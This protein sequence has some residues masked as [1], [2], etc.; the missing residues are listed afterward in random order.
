ML[1]R[2]SRISNDDRPVAIVV[3]TEWEFTPYRGL[4]PGLRTVDGVGPWEVYEARAG[5]QTVVLIVSGAG[6]VNAAAAT[7]RLIAGF[8]PVAVLHGG[9]AGA[10]NPALMPGDI[11]LGDRYIIAAPDT[12]RQARV[13]RGLHPSLIRFRRH[14]MDVHLA[15]IVA[16][17]ELLQRAE[18]LARQHADVLG[19]WEAPGW[20]ADLPRRAGMVVTG[21]IASAD[22]WTVEPIELRRLHDEFGAE[23]EDME[24]AYVA[25]VCAMHEL[26]FVA[27][28]VISNNDVVSPLAPEEVQPALAAAGY[29][30]ALVLTALAAGIP[31]ANDGD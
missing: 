30:A 13:A 3:P 21:A 19:A 14:G 8:R 24:S 6:P 2:M 4:L 12:V 22:A 1:R 29:R 28:R 9:S 27:V 5:D 25:Q 17:P 10:H 23:C 7:E 18:L 15:E 16:N 11:V 20:P 26:P 31:A